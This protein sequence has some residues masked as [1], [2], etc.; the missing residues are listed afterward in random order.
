MPPDA[1]IPLCAQPR[2]QASINDIVYMEGGGVWPKMAKNN[3]EGSGCFNENS[4]I[5]LTFKHFKIGNF[6]EVP[7]HAL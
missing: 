7:T 1:F 6:G 2:N 5:S 4:A 3:E